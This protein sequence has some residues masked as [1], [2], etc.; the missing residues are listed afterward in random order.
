M[1]TPCPGSGLLVFSSSV[2]SRHPLK[3]QATCHNCFRVFQ[4]ERVKRRREAVYEYEGW[5]PEHE[6]R[7]R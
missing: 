5:F 3:V 1:T 2:F 4:L 7:L 6:E